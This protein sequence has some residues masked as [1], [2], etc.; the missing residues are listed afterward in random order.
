MSGNVSFND[1]TI[2]E[3]FHKYFVLVAQNI[4]V[5]NHNVNVLSNYENPISYLSRAFNQQF[6]TINLKCISSKET[7]DI[8]KSLTTKNSHRY[9]EIST[10]ILKLGIYY[11]FS[12]STYIC[13][14]CYLLV[15]FQQD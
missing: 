13:N 10:T 5:N 12:P 2:A 1:Q 4:H 7:E 6:P 3:T 11:I 8:T 14:E 9:E 15:F